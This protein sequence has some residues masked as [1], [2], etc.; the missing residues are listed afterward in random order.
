[1][2]KPISPSEAQDYVSDIPDYII[3]IFNTLI[4]KSYRNGRAI[5]YQKEVERFVESM[6]GGK[7]LNQ[8]FDNGWFDVE[9]LYENEG[10]KVLYDKPGYNETYEAYYE[11]IRE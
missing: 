10:W 8:A 11:F 2:T 3:D 7:Q 4:K 9:E 5:V 1:M 6:V